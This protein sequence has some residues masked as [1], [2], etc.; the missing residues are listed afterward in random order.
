LRLAPIVVAG[1]LACGLSAF[2]PPPQP[3]TVE[4][5]ESLFV[6]KPEAAGTKRG[7]YLMW[8]PQPVLK[9]CVGKTF[10]ECASIDYCIRTTNKDVPMCR[11]LGVDVTRLPAYPPDVLPRRVLSITCSAIV[12]MPGYDDLLRYLENAPKETLD[13]LTLRARI[14]ARIK[15]TRS[16][17]DDQFQLLEVLAVPPS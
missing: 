16:T 13:R 2:A 14:K 12:G 4:L 17:D 7:A 8:V 1:L 6:Q 11:N 5:E 15:L 9:Y 10:K 3:V